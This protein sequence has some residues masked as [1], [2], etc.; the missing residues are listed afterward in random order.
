MPNSR[1]VYF[2]VKKER[3]T[4]AESTLER[5]VIVLSGLC[6]KSIPLLGSIK[7]VSKCESCQRDL[8]IFN[9]SGFLPQMVNYDE[10]LICNT[11]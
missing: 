5:P 7:S 4:T 8:V 9:F 2:T 11:R 3:V 6:V 10:M 1:I